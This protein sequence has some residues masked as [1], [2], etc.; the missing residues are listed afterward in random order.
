M[1][2]EGDLFDVEIWQSHDHLPSGVAGT[3]GIDPEA[4]QAVES[5]YVVE[6]SPKVSQAAFVACLPE[7]LSKHRGKWVAFADGKLLR[8]AASQS[9]LYRY[10]LSE[11]GLTHTRFVIRRVVPESEPQIE[12]TLR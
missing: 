5:A 10:C 11:L 4:S 7:L 8:L 9:E 3:D 6:S 12:Y 2:R 1:N